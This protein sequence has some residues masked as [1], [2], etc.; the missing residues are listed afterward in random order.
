[1][2]DGW[3]R[4]RGR[5]GRHFCSSRTALHHPRA[6]IGRC[7][8]MRH[9]VQATNA[10]VVFQEVTKAFGQVLAV[11]KLNLQVAQGELLVLLGPSGCGKTTSLR[12]LAELERIS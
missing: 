3:Q 10:A 1:Q 7:D 4:F 12:M 9:G 11:N 2:Y 6:R 8:G 5:A